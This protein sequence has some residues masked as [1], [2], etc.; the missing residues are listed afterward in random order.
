MATFEYLA[1]DSAGRNKKGVL[2]ADTEKQARQK[3][4]TQ[5][6][7]PIKLEE[8][9]GDAQKKRNR[10]RYRTRIGITETALVTRQLATLVRSGMPIVE[11][12]S[13]IAE[14]SEKRKI[15]NTALTVRGRV[16]EGYA[17]A[18]AL[19]EFPGVFS[20]MYRATVE[21]GEHSGHLDAVLERLAD[22]M[23]ERQASSQKMLLAF[24]YPLILIVVSILVVAGLLA[25]VVPEVTRVYETSGQTL[26]A[27]TVF[28]IGMSEG[29]RNYGL[30]ISASLLA[31]LI[32][33]RQLYRIE[34]IAERVQILLL[35][36][37]LVGRLIR[38]YNTG[39]FTRAMSILSESGVPILD[40]LRVSTKVLS[41]LAMRN[42]VIKATSDV[43]EG[44]SLA[45]SL[46]KSGRFPV[47]TLRLIAAGESGGNLDSMLGRAADAQDR[48][49]STATALLLGILEPALILL[50]GGVVLFVVMAILLPIFDLN[51]LVR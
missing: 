12:L 25:Y 24:L 39:Q 8:L 26:P 11:A 38:G 48:E 17:F 21:A 42:S 29:L 10:K 22:Y 15:R 16:V 40:A 44:M 45:N 14:Q 33:F 34:S 20:E 47:I 35:K 43:R 18:E 6:L 32:F 4:R 9:Q 27:I 36:L 37:P 49:L 5:S 50:M 23:E 31:L 7:L 3:L 28:L 41:N 51:Q 2:D 30:W 46:E 13:A 1:V 19:N